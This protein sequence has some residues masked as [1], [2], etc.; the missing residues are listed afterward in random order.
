MVS[1]NLN[2]A[3]KVLKKKQNKSSENMF[4][5]LECQGILRKTV[6]ES[7]KKANIITWSNTLTSMPEPV[8]NFARKAMQ[9]QL[10]TAANLARWKKI[11][12]SF[13]QLCNSSKPQINKHVLSNCS[14][15]AALERYKRRHNGI[16]E[17]LADWLA[18]VLSPN[19]NLFVDITSEKFHPVGVI[20]KAERLDTVI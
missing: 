19:Q 8:Y 18:S 17:T 2:Q 4:F 12:D 15:L 1:S 11:S 5:S 3:V 9:Q 16:L 20:F 7:V 10:P 6:V 13:C 14:S